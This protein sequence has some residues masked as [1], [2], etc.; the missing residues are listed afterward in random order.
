MITFCLGVE[1]SHDVFIIIFKHLVLHTK[2]SQYL[3][4]SLILFM[5]IDLHFAYKQTLLLPIVPILKVTIT[6]TSARIHFLF[7]QE[8]IQ[9][10][11]RN[12]VTCITLVVLAKTKCNFPYTCI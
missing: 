12:L 5:F 2:N 3:T 10:L 11:K 4:K 1:K 8:A 6:L 7:L 9:F